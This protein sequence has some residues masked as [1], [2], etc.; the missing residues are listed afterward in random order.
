MA[1][2]SPRTS[3]AIP[4][5]MND[6]RDNDGGNNMS[7]ATTIAHPPNKRTKLTSFIFSFPETWLSSPNF[8]GQRVK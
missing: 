6:G 7:A 5:N 8:Q 3:T 1:K 4:A 2:T